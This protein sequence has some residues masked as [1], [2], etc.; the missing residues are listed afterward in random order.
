MKYRLIS[1]MTVERKKKV[2]N[3]A[4]HNNDLFLSFSLVIKFHRKRRKKKE[5]VINRRWSRWGNEKKKLLKKTL[6]RPPSSYYKINVEWYQ[7]S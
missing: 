4:K 7:Q 5:K 2:L 1:I 3:F 6:R